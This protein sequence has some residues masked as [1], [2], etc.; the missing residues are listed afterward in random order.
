M[1]RGFSSNRCFP[2]RA[3]ASASFGWA[4]GATAMTTA[5]TA[6]IMSSNCPNGLTPERRGERSRAL[7]VAPPEA[8]ELDSVTRREHR[9]MD[10]LGQ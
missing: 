10:F 5:S 2:A 7:I 9:Q 4:C 3:A 6:A 8:D 1:A